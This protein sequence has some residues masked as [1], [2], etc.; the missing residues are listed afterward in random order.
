MT[1]P[2]FGYLTAFIPA[3]W[4]SGR[5]AKQL[6]MNDFAY[7][8]FATIAGLAVVHLFGVIY[9]TLGK[10]I[11]SWELPVSQLIYNYSIAPL[12]GQIILCPSVGFISLIFRRML[13][14]E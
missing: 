11:A 1:T 9:L 5:L 10:S 13:F 12:P 3:A 2:S 14:I 4:I 8:T 7:L 6:G